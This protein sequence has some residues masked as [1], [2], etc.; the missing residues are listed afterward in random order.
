MQESE[1]RFDN[2]PMPAFRVPIMFRSMGRCSEMG[3]TMGH[4]EGSES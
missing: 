4:K 1:T 3:D 2:V